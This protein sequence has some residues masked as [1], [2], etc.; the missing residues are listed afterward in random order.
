M[1]SLLRR[2]GWRGSYAPE[3]LTARGASGF[4]RN[5]RASGNLLRREPSVSGSAFPP[6]ASAFRERATAIERVLQNISG[7]IEEER[8]AAPSVAQYPKPE[9]VG[10]ARLI[11][12]GGGLETVG[13]ELA[14]AG[15][16]S[17]P[18]AGLK[19]PE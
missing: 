2:F 1:F 16:L 6:E 11:E 13:R 5:V 7:L 12:R 15:A 10:D 8:K 17:N 18:R 19:K 4:L 3:R 9:R 14:P